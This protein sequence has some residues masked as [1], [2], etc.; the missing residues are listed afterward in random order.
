MHV[1][2]P[3]VG[4]IVSL[5]QRRSHIVYRLAYE[6]VKPTFGTVKQKKTNKKNVANQIYKTGLH[7]NYFRIKMLH[8][9]AFECLFL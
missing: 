6:A 5:A 9:I 8:F 7:T 3:N 1:T 4:V 2:I